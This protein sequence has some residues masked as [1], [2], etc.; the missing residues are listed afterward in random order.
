[1]SQGDKLKQL[2][3]IIKA[4]NPG[5]TQHDICGLLDSYNENDEGKIKAPFPELWRVPLT[6]RLW[7]EVFEKDSERTKM[8]LTRIEPAT[9]GL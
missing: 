5:I 7:V 1:M 8:F 6:I 9:L 2:V 4:S 3:A